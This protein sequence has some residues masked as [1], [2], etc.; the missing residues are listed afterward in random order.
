M[1][2][3]TISERDGHR[4]SALIGRQ[5]S[6]GSFRP[7]RA[8]R[9]SQLMLVAIGVYFSSNLAL[10]AQT[11]DSQPGDANTSWTATTETQGDQ[12]YPTR[13]IE[14]HT[15]TG[16][17]TLD[18]QSVQRRG[19]DGHFEPYQDIEKETVQVDATTVRTTTRTFGR[20]LDG[21]KTLLQVTEEDKHTV[22]GGD[23]NV[24]RVT[25][26]SD[27]NGN[28]QL[29]QRQIEETKKISKDVEET[30]TTVMLPSVDG[31]LAPAM[32]VQ[33]RRTRRANDTA[34]SQKTTLLP[35]GAGNWQVGEIRQAT[36]TQE[37]KNSSTEER[38]SRPDSEGKLGEV[39]RTV[40]KESESA[41]G[42]K[43]NTVETYSVDVPGS[44]R[45]GS[46]HLVERA[47][48]A[49]RTSSTGEQTT[50]RQVEQP[51]PGD[52][53]SGLRVTTLTTDAVRPGSSGAQATRTIQVRNASGSL[54]VISVDTT[55][56]D[57]I[58]AVQVQIAPLAPSENPK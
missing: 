35:D 13:S 23:S 34:E 48:T 49:Q 31:G 30:K 29:V 26:N 44:A 28:L 5:C 46:L 21:A 20:D 40:N 25:S 8:A 10:W 42:E 54:E 2:T 9:F 18:K 47:N 6:D 27:V 4:R 53:G 39:F 55:K 50:E 43:R 3:P 12:L 33:E 36:T 14:S 16:D 1:A 58:H 56:S 11:S 57:N 7:S 52:P 19:S 38:V 51:N 17:R 45:D 41:P 15:Q 22:P 37:G 24:V 32:K